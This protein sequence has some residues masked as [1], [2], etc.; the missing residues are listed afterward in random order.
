MCAWLDVTSPRLNY[1]LPW[2]GRSR[3]RVSECQPQGAGLSAHLLTNWLH[4]SFSRLWTNKSDDCPI[5]KRTLLPNCVNINYTHARTHTHTHTVLSLLI[6]F[7]CVDKNTNLL[8]LY[9]TGTSGSSSVNGKLYLHVPLF[10]P[11]TLFPRSCLWPVV[12]RNISYF[13]LLLLY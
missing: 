2:G 8:K 3:I 13:R 10:P 12:Q 6:A 1:E 9:V 5:L 4:Q 7:D 11:L